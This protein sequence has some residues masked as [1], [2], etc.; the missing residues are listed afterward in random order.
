MAKV[1]RD[2]RTHV[3]PNVCTTASRIRDFTRMNPLMFYGSN[4]EEDP[5]GFIDEILNV[6]DAM[7]V[8]PQQKA[9][10]SA[11]QLKDVAQVWHEK[12]M[13]EGLLGAGPEQKLKQVN[14]EVERAR[15][16]DGDSSNGKFEGQ[17]RPRFKRRFSNQ[18]SSSARWINKDKVSKSKHQ[19][20]NSGRSSMGRRT[21]GKCGK[22]HDG[23]CLGGMGVFYGC[24]KSGNQLKNFPT[25]VAKGREDKQI[26]PSGS[27]SDASKKNFFYS[28]QFGGVQESSPDVMIGML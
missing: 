3:N 6:L 25:L 8:F 17:G 15:T 1:N 13:G 23:K 12:W 14:R 18:G 27:N 7:R 19:G 5:Q 24:G 2:T 10:L 26:P 11:Y 4:V 20:D 9:K 16:D 21:C 22:K 28:L